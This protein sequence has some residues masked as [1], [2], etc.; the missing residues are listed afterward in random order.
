[1]NLN[2]EQLLT[3]YRMMKTIRDFEERVHVEFS[4]ADVNRLVQQF[5]DGVPS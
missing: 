4:A 3:A 1:M 5:L 2:K